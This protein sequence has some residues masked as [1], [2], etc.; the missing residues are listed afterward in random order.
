MPPLDSSRPLFLPVLQEGL[1]MTVTLV[2]QNYGH[3]STFLGLRATFEQLV[4]EWL[5]A[6]SRPV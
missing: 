5:R 2:R 4:V 6:D 1:S 3:V